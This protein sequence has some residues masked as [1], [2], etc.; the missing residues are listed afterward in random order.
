MEQ[1]NR[2]GSRVKKLKKISSYTEKFQESLEKRVTI[3]DIDITR[4][5]LKA[6]EKIN[7]PRFTTSSRW[8]K[9][10]KMVR[11]IISRKI[12]FITKKNYLIKR[13]SR[14]RR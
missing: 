13:T 1:I 14:S 5:A 11:N 6:Q 2:G 9:K 3:H 12:K 8:V 10:F 4:W 7:F